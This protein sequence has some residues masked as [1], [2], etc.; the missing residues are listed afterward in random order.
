MKHKT[1]HIEIVE[2]AAIALQELCA[3]MVFVGG[4][5]ISLYTDDASSDEIRPTKDI[6][7]TIRIKSYSK[8]VS[9]Q[10]RLA[11]LKFFP[12]PSGM[13]VCSFKF[14]DILIDIMPSDIDV[15]GKPNRW[16]DS[17]IEDLI[18]INLGETKI[19]I[20]SAPFFLA[21]KFE[22]FNGRGKDYRTSHDF[23]DIL[24]VIDNRKN[25]VKEILESETSVKNYLM[26]EFGNF[27]KRYDYDETLSAHIHPFVAEERIPMVKEKIGKIING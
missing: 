7:L 6:D 11:Q 15:F 21:T 9:L 3:E 18:M 25:I 12:D 23:E 16:Y 26:K 22:A 8:L 13:S 14:E 4:A 17:G 20:L 27:A 2:K 19:R 24:Y 1:I 10:E 5:I